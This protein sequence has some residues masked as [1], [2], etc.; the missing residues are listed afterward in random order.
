MP[1]KKNK[2]VEE[3]AETQPPIEEETTETSLEEAAIE[4]ST[5]EPVVEEPPKKEKK[6]TDT[7]KVKVLIGTLKW[8]LGTFENGEVFECS[9][10][11][12]LSFGNSVEI[13][14]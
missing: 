9:R 11:R 8:E 5:V 1:K 12:A 3:T 14:E 6:P 2:V 4:E 7:V 10:E 13:L